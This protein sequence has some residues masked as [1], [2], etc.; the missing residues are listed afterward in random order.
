MIELGETHNLFTKLCRADGPVLLTGPTGSGKTYL[1][2]KIHAA[3]K[4]S[5]RP[6]VVVNLA[7]LNENL[8]ESE[9][10][11]HE[12]GAFSGALFR[13]MGKLEAA[14]GGTVLL[15]EIGELPLNLQ[16]RLL[17][18]LNNQTISL[19]GS[20]RETRLDI[21]I[22]S[23]TNRN[24][25]EMVQTGAFRADLFYRVKV[26]HLDLPGITSKP[27]RILACIGAWIADKRAETGRELSISPKLESCLL[28]HSWPGNIRELRN[29]LE[30]ALAFAEGDLLS[31]DILPKEFFSQPS[32]PVAKT[33]IFPINYHEAK[34]AFERAF[35]LQALRE[36]HGRINATA[37]GTQLSK[38]TLIEKIKAYGIDLAAIKIE[39]LTKEK[40]GNQTRYQ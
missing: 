28:Q 29:V 8:I 13:R 11:G 5:P 32:G 22:I 6:F 3:S 20:N 17:E 1:A 40:S 30:Y 10:F 25:G 26:F 21:R 9:L 14:N 38:V 34:A 27:E 39:A 33:Q 7:T 36:H 19:V 16:V 18:V 4:R 35:L 15:D 23:A 31:E 12:R 2:A 37:R 24:L